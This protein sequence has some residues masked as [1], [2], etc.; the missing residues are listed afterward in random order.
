MS[1]FNCMFGAMLCIFEFVLCIITYIAWSSSI[2]NNI[3]LIAMDI[4][5]TIFDIL[6]FALVVYLTRKKNENVLYI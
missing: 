1:G 2:I 6:L 4:G 5:F 3:E